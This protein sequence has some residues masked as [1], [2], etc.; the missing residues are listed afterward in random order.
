M[1]VAVDPFA[2]DTTTGSPGPDAETRTLP[3]VKLAGEPLRRIGTGASSRHS[4]V[5]SHPVRMFVAVATR[6]IGAN[7]GVTFPERLTLAC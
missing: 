3:S 2:V 4:I 1:R 6:A 5:K 7:P